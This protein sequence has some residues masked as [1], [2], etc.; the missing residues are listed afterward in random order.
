MGFRYVGF[1][2]ECPGPGTIN[3]SVILGL[4]LELSLKLDLGLNF[5]SLEPFSTVG[6]EP[7]TFSW[8]RNFQLRWV[9]AR[10]SGAFDLGIFGAWNL[11]PFSN[12][13]FEPKLILG[14]NFWSL[15][16]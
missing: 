6:F 2:P 3:L 5:W 8:N 1:G 15:H 4:N 16:P 9:W 14:L 7:E 11:E 12:F 13:G 10:V